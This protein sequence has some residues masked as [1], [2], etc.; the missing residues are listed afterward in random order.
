[1]ADTAV[2]DRAAAVRA[3]AAERQRHQPVHSDARSTRNLEEA[4]RRCAQRGVVHAAR[5]ERHRVD[6]GRAGRCELGLYGGGSLEG[7][8]VRVEH[9]RAVD[10]Q[11]EHGGAGTGWWQSRR[12]CGDRAR[13][14]PVR[15]EMPVVPR[16]GTERLRKLSVA[17][18]HHRAHGPGVAERSDCRRASR[19]AAVQRFEPCRSRCACLVPRQSERRTCARSW[20]WAW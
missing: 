7:H 16:C 19:Y 3:A 18:G 17:C 9:Q 1:M 4:H 14:C 15:P 6:P 20:S 8:R 5:V 11:A 13:P 2:P 12:T 10:L